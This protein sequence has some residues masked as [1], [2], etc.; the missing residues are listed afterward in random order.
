MG[1][2]DFFNN[3]T[4]KRPGS[5]VRD[6]KG[7]ILEV[8]GKDGN[9]SSAWN[10]LASMSDS[11]IKSLMNNKYDNDYIDG[12]K[13]FMGEEFGKA[14]N[15]LRLALYSKM[16]TKSFK[17]N[18]S[19]FTDVDP[20]ID[21]RLSIV[22][23]NGKEAYLI[24]DGSGNHRPP[25]EALRDNSVIQTLDM[26]LK[27]NPEKIKLALSRLIGKTMAVDIESQLLSAATDNAKELILA[28]I[29]SNEHTNGIIT[30]MLVLGYDI[31]D[32]LDFLQ[33]SS[34]QRLLAKLQ[35]KKGKEETNNLSTSFIKKS[36][37]TGPA[38]DTLLRIVDVSSSIMAFGGIRSLS[39]NFKIDSVS[40]DR[41]FDSLD[42][43]ALYKAI[44][45]RDLTQIFDKGE[46]V[47][48]F[49][50]AAII[51]YHPQSRA[52]F[53]RLYELENHILPKMFK[54]RQYVK[55]FIGPK[56]RTE[57]AYKNTLKYMAASQLAHFL[58]TPVDGKILTGTLFDRAG[59]A[60]HYELNEVENREKFVS[61]F[62]GYIDAMK[63]KFKDLNIQN[64]AL[65]NM[66]EVTK[67]G[68]T[69]QIMSISKYKSGVTDDHLK[70]GI[71]AA[72][73]EL[74]KTL[75][76]DTAEI[77]AAKRQLYSNLQMY[78]LIVS[79]GVMSKAT[80]LELYVEINED[81]AHF[82]NGLD[83]EFYAKILK[84]PAP[85]KKKGK[86]G[87]KAQEDELYGDMTD[88]EKSKA[89]ERADID[90]GLRNVV[91]DTWLDEKFKVK[92][93][94]E[95]EIEKLDDATD[96]VKE[97]PEFLKKPKKTPG[98]LGGKLYKNVVLDIEY[99]GNPGNYPYRIFNSSS[100][101]A[102]PVGVF[103]SILSDIPGVTN[104][105]ATVLAATGRR[106]GYPI[107]LGG[108]RAVILSYT[109]K[110]K[111]LIGKIP[112]YTYNVLV[113]G[114]NGKTETVNVEASAIM[115]ENPTVGV[116]GFSIGPMTAAL[117][118]RI[119]NDNVTK[120]LKALVAKSS[121]AK[122]AKLAGVSFADIST[123]T[124]N[125]FEKVKLTTDQTQELQIAEKIGFNNV[126]LASEEVD[127]SNITKAYRQL[128]TDGLSIEADEILI[129]S[130]ASEAKRFPH[131]IAQSIAKELHNRII[132]MNNVINEEAPLIVHVSKSNFNKAGKNVLIDAF[133]IVN[134]VYLNNQYS[135]EVGSTDPHS[136]T[137]TY[138]IVKEAYS[139]A[140][141]ESKAEKLLS[142]NGSKFG[143]YF[144]NG[145]L[146]VTTSIP[147]KTDKEIKQIRGQMKIH[148]IASGLD[149]GMYRSSSAVFESDGR[150][151]LGIKANKNVTFIY[152]INEKNVNLI[153]GIDVSV[154]TEEGA[155]V[156]EGIKIAYVSIKNDV[157]LEGIANEAIAE[158]LAE[159]IKENK[160][161]NKNC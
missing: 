154:G 4:A 11:N 117:S 61:G 74:K 122:Y 52:I 129:P 65:D 94:E 50:T 27:D 41:I 82:I 16:Y 133:S 153:E 84:K 151:F 99:L 131:R 135:L 102:S 12:L 136:S 22:A 43:D 57:D 44:K 119:S 21:E 10:V 45:N 126:L 70:G 132:E 143:T 76:T 157:K 101:E 104:T 120:N 54:S 14:P 72:I 85:R 42:N 112:N 68:S 30:A 23:A 141:S 49:N 48:I 159:V 67:P 156:E 60:Q 107:K 69:K 93:T 55:E 124:S 92:L 114:E 137:V 37:V 33:D 160:N 80:N 25:S 15:D 38:I 87:K 150:R 73:R 1:C 32:V 39:E 111:P 140:S 53:K 139:V 20:V 28:K 148:A 77:T 3:T 97:I 9:V 6:A 89:K 47:G 118:K 51:Y 98:R 63:V 144:E 145:D 88:T 146:K 155:T 19:D 109:G 83:N 40:L 58:D 71:E 106:I 36:G 64:I 78:N 152:S 113:E 108:K 2:I 26:L 149:G 103:R 46:S 123:T 127:M 138:K 128:R 17:N 13:D 96:I 18:V 95:E 100:K 5:V 81:F 66:V 29:G 125:A 121:G 116:H 134:S 158:S 56:S 35:Q 147:G 24:G 34:V 90:E 110:T 130:L 79:G 115:I 161:K 62:P 91:L 31:N 59:V 86:K 105:M 142:L 8:L 75:P 7:N